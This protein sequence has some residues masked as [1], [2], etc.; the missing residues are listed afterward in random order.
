MWWYA[1]RGFT[2]EG[3]QFPNGFQLFTASYSKLFKKKNI[4]K[5]EKF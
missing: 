4:N 1:H 2:S 5:T 3:V